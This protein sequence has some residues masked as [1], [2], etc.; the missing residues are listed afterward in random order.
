MLEG[1]VAE[2]LGD[3]AVWIAVITLGGIAAVYRKYQLMERT[4]FGEAA[5]EDDDGILGKLRDLEKRVDN[6]EDDKQ[7][8]KYRKPGKGDSD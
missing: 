6:L 3:M 1:I 5:L 4:L 7:Q 2:V 8:R